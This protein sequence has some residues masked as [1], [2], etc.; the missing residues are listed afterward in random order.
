MELLLVS[1][2]LEQAIIWSGGHIPEGRLSWLSERMKHSLCF[3][4]QHFCELSAY[5]AVTGNA[6]T[7]QFSQTTADNLTENNLAK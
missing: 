1:E 2:I 6:K 7:F 3:S 5:Q 4:V